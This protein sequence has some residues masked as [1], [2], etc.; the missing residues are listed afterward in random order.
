LRFREITLEE[1]KA[2]M[3]KENENT[4][5]IPYIKCRIESIISFHHL[6]EKYV[7]R[8]TNNSIL[9][10]ILSDKNENKIYFEKLNGEN[11]SLFNH[12]CQDFAA[13]IIKI[14]EAEIDQEDG[15]YGEDYN[16]IKVYVPKKI[17]EALE[18]N[19]NKIISED[20]DNDNPTTSINDDNAT[21]YSNNSF[22]ELLKYDLIWK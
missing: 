8:N 17:V 21:V 11:Y 22:K 12:N 7:L 13:K 6:I 16:N 5:N 3:N 2:K 19:S 4:N 10:K 18:A 20:L 14:I 9:Y 1:F 15:L